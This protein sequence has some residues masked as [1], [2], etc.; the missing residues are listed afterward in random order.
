MNIFTKSVLG[1]VIVVIATQ[2]IAM[3]AED[4]QPP[5]IATILS[6][7]KEINKEAK[8]T[9]TEKKTIKVKKI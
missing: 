9:S 8:K 6:F 7:L 4:P 5:R 3:D 1:L 2:A